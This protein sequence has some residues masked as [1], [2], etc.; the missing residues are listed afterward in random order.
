MGRH[1]LPD[2][3]RAGSADPRVRARRRNTALA[4][5][6]V[7]TVVGGTAAAVRGGLFSFES[8]CD[9]DTVR[10]EVAASPDIAP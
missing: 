1:S 3:R 5:A 7:L 10:I 6:L 2:A 4:T 8:S 9:D